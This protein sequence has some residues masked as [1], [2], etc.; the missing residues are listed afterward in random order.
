MLKDIGWGLV[1]LVLIVYGTVVVIRD[2]RRD[3]QRQR[4]LVESTDIEAERERRMRTAR[5]E[6]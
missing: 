5:N 2:N 4:R 3:R 6:R 1:V